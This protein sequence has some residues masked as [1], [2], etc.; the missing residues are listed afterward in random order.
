MANRGLLSALVHLEDYLNTKLMDNVVWS[1]KEELQKE[2]NDLQK[3]LIVL[4]RLPKLME[5]KE[6]GTNRAEPTA[7][8]QKEPSYTTGEIQCRFT[9][10]E[11]S[12]LLSALELYAEKSAV[13]ETLMRKIEDL[14]EDHCVKYSLS[15]ALVAYNE[16]YGTWG[17]GNPTEEA[18]WEGFR[19]AYYLTSSEQHGEG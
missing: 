17:M 15:P 16:K 1:H 6:E 3:L 14:Y 11:V 2:I 12:T 7:E 9:E 5:N 19:D 10:E 4:G 8:P 18:R 13:F